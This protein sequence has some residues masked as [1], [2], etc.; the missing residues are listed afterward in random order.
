MATWGVHIRIAEAILKENRFEVDKTSFLVGNIA[1]DA[2]MPNADW[3]QFT[4]PPEISHWKD[5]DNIINPQLFFDSNLSRE[6][7]D[8]KEWSFLVGYYV[9]LMTDVEWVGMIE[10][11]RKVNT[12]YD[13]LKTDK[14]FIWEIK[15]DWY[16]LDHKYFRDN[17]VNIFWTDFQ[18]IK[19]FPNYLDYFSEDAI[20]SRM[21][22]ITEFYNNPSEDLDREYKY[23]QMK[24]M[25]LFL[26]KTVRIITDELNSKLAYFDDNLV[27][28]K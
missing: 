8:R 28:L 6:I 1:P 9:H 24:D 7:E 16:D 22:Y 18:Y 19:E 3:S 12:D 5:D 17:P 4:P 14:N 20:M 23:L 21:N 10:D 27:S 15:K 2:G 26:N 11:T 13:K 25:N